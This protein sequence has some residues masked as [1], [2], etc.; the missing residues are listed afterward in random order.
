[1]AETAAVH[2]TRVDLPKSARRGEIVRVKTIIAHPMEIGLRLDETGQRVEQRLI[3]RFSCVV[4]GRTVFSAELYTGIAANPY[5]VF[6]F[7][8]RESGTVEFRW[9]DDDGNIYRE[10]ASIEVT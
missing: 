7:R 3:N 1:M 4:N 5:L 9:H 2:P 10:T 6:Y 8:A